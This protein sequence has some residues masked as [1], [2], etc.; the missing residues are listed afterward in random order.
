MRKLIAGSLM[1]LMAQSASIQIINPKLLID[2]VA[3]ENGFIENGM[4]NFGHIEY[5]QTIV[6]SVKCEDLFNDFSDIA[7]SS[8]RTI[9]QYKWM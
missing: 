6:S 8:I 1:G 9:D 2:R 5:G 3:D 4:A 7:R